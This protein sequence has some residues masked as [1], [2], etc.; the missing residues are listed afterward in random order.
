M[1]DFTQLDKKR[2][3]KYAIL[4]KEIL[5]RLLERLNYFKMQPRMI[6]DLQIQWGLSTRSLKKYFP[7]AMVIGMGTSFDCVRYAETKKTW[8]HDFDVIQAQMTQLP[9]S[10]ASVDL[11]FMQQCLNSFDEL[12]VIIQE[13][14]RIL[15]PGGCLLFSCL[16]PDSFKEIEYS[17][18]VPL[19]D[20]HDIGDLLL[21][22]GF[23]DPVMDREDIVLKYASIDKLE[24]HLQAQGYTLSHLFKTTQLT[25]EIIYGQAWRDLDKPKNSTEKI[26]SLES[27]RK[28]LNHKKSRDL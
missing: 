7:K 2:F 16:G 5:K 18:Q 3:E 4:Q 27:L 28:S 22:E 23:L 21:R 14:Y 19:H 8:W 6:L 10:Q 26:I 20:L 25:Y 1:I 11:I 12:Q 17:L 13:C 15:K 24:N 9:L